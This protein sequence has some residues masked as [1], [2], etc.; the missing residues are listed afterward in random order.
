VHRLERERLENEKVEC[1]AQYISGV[2]GRRRQ[3]DNTLL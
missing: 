2:V 1:A 3:L